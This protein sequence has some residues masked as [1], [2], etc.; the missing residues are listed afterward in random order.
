[1]GHLG[2]CLHL[3]RPLL[4][5]QQL[6]WEVSGRFSLSIEEESFLVDPLPFFRR[7]IFVAMKEFYALLDLRDCFLTSTIA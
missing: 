3:Q 5:V 6:Q 1:M 7:I 2:L 4:P